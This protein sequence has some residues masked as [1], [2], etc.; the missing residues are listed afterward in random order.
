MARGMARVAGPGSTNG[1]VGFDAPGSAPESRTRSV[2]LSAATREANARHFPPGRAVPGHA[3]T[4]GIAPLR[5]APRGPVPAARGAR[6]SSIG[7]FRPFSR[8][9]STAIS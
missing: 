5:L 8:A 3:I 6:Y 9:Q 7:S 2:A 4:L 1:H